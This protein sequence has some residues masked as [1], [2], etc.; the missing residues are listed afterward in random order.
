M[1]SAETFAAATED[2]LAREFVP[3]SSTEILFYCANPEVDRRLAILRGL[4]RR[5]RVAGIVVLRATYGGDSSI[6]CV[7]RCLT[8][9][10]DYRQYGSYGGELGYGHQITVG[11]HGG[12]VEAGDLY[13]P[14]RTDR[15]QRMPWLDDV[16]YSEVTFDGRLPHSLAQSTTQDVLR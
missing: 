10:S 8:T 9:S 2:T 15:P 1:A 3:N 11:D 6:I 14:S 13:I 16:V 7:D 4:P 5:A 12:M